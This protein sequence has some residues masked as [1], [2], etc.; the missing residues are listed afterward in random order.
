MD[1]ES[2]IAIYGTTELAE[3][4]Y[5][6]LR[7]MGVTSI[8]VF[9]THHAGRRFLGMPVG[10]LDSIEPSDYVKVAVAFSEDVGAR[11]QELDALGV[12]P[13]QVITLLQSSNHGAG[14]ASQS[15]AS[16]EV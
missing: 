2:R 7:E 13:S 8:D 10:S 3:L 11:C 6:V 9:D 5:L 4:M 16:E 12:S 14:A 15:K 1:A